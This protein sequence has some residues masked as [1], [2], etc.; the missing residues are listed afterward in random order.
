MDTFVFDFLN[1]SESKLPKSLKE[2]LKKA[3]KEGTP[4]TMLINPPYGQCGAGANKG[5]NKADVTKTDIAMQM[6]SV[7]LGKAANELTV[8]F[9]FRIMNIVKEYGIKDKPPSL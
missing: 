6:K 4:F 2:A 3:G 5:G 9:L 7:G 8:Q 1:D